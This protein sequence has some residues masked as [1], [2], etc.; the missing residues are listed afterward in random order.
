MKLKILRGF[1]QGG[2]IANLAGL[3]IGFGIGQGSLF[4]AQTWLLTTGRIDFLAEFSLNFTFLILAYQAIDFGGL[5]ILARRML[6]NDP[7][8]DLTTFFWSFS[9]VRLMIALLILIGTIMW[10]VHSPAEFAP[11]YSVSACFGLLALAL[12]PGGLLDGAGRSGWNGA[13]WSLPFVASTFALPFSVDLPP[14]SAGQL[15]GAALSLGGV[16]ATVAQF[17]LLSRLAL[18]PGMGR[19]TRAAA[20]AGWREGALYTIGWMPG[21]IY[22]RGQAAITLTLLGPTAVA[23]L[24]YAKQLIMIATR[25]LYFARRVEFRNLVQRLSKGGDL[26]QTVFS[27]QRYS[28]GLAF[29]G[30]AGFV[31]VGLSMDL[32]FREVTHGAGLVV[33]YFSVV[34]VSASLFSTFTQA[35]YAMQRTKLAASVSIGVAVFGLLLQ[36]GMGKL[37]GLFGIVLAEAISQ[38]TGVLLLILMLRAQDRS[39]S[40]RR[41]S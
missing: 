4:V 2:R 13:T 36:A 38:V 18:H 20:L 29:V 16:A 12:N 35:C 24:I 1:Q 27:V 10:W 23:L 28:L 25:F 17:G 6:V 3:L 14:A 34:I 5:V 19:P 26:V 30:A 40:V 9:A 15:L 39:S 31:A 7:Q 8:L 22:F 33:I 41:L 21:Q 37:L 11:N 32:F